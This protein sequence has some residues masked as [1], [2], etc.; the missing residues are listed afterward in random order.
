[1]D[2]YRWH[3]GPSRLTEDR[4]RDTELTL[5]RIPFV[6]FTYDQVAERPDYVARTVLAMLGAS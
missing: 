4:V 1:M 3:R 6:R 5:A 2:S